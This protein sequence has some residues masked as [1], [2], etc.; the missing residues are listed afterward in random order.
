VATFLLLDQTLDVL[1]YGPERVGFR[2]FRAFQVGT[3]WSAGGNPT[4]DSLR[5]VF[6]SSTEGVDPET[7]FI[8]VTASPTSADYAAWC[9]VGPYLHLPAG[10]SVSVTIAFAV[11]SGSVAEAASYAGDYAAY[12]AGQLSGGAL[13]AAHPP[14]TNVFAAQVLHDGTYADPQPGALVPDFHGRETP[15]KAPPGQVILI[16]GCPDRDPNPR[17]V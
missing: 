6:M 3:P 14:L 10:A 1:K 2:A 7:G 16:Q 13:L 8:S 11:Q 9:S 12:R 15:V 17:F 5:W 4:S